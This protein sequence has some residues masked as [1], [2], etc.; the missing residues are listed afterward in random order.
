MYFILEL[1]AVYS[2]TYHIVCLEHHTRS[3][4]ELFISVMPRVLSLLILLCDLNYSSSKS[5]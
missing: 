4:I 2:R 1:K 3:E 5:S